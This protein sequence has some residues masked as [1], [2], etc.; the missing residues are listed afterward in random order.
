MTSKSESEVYSIV[1]ILDKSGSMEIMGNEPVQSMNNF[2]KTQKDNNLKFK[3]TLVLFN[4]K[5]EFLLKNIDSEEIEEIKTSDYVPNGMTSLYDA[6][7]Q[8]IVYQEEQNNDNVIFVILTDGHENSSSKYTNSMIKKMISDKES[9]NKWKF[10]FLAANQD[11][12]TVGANLGI[13][14]DCCSNFV[15]NACGLNNI[16]REISGTIS[17]TL[18]STVSSDFE[19]IE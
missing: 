16:M 17:A 8:S 10:N 18:S 13:P 4:D 19:K 7:G 11:S 12:F 15:Y 6:I 9:I 14:K 3:F 1:F 2:I 5:V